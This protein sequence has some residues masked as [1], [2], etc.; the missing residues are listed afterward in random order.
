MMNP[1]LIEALNLGGKMSEITGQLFFRRFVKG[2]PETFYIVAL[3]F[4]GSAG[5]KEAIELADNWGCEG[6]TD[7]INLKV[8]GE[9]LPEFI[10]DAGPG[11]PYHG[12]KYLRA[13]KK[14][15]EMF[16]AAK[17]HD[18]TYCSHTQKA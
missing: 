18:N 2:K 8:S 10:Q 12:E 11:C 17:L 9:T 1:L 5:V 6:F 3:N 7:V 13:S 4:V 14:P 16:C 15:G